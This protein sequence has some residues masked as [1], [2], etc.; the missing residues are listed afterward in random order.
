MSYDFSLNSFYR[1]IVQ[2][3]PMIQILQNI[4]P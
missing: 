3:M 1:Q 4:V 2:T